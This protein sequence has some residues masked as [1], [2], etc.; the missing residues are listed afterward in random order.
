MPAPNP[1]EG[2]Q[3]FISRCMGDAEAR[4]SFP[5]EQQRAAF[6][7]SQ[8]N[9]RPHMAAMNSCDMPGMGKRR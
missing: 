4:R 1:N 5:N 3:E 6:C 2:Q 8:W 7:Y 9:H